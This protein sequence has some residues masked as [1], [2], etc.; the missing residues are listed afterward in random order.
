M[1]TWELV[2]ILSRMPPGTTVSTELLAQLVEEPERNPSRTKPEEGNRRL[3]LGSLFEKS[4]LVRKH[5]TRQEF[6]RRVYSLMISKGMFQSDLARAA[7][8]PRDSISNYVRGNN[9]PERV[10]L[11]KLADALEVKPDDLLPNLAEQAIELDRESPLEIKASSADPN[12]VWLRVHRMVKKSAL[13]KIL[14]AIDE[15]ADYAESADNDR[16]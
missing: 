11:K 15:A 2:G 12:Y 14:A 5:L 4:A 7:G 8:L 6:A 3:S 16:E 10:N 13:P 1:N 9:M